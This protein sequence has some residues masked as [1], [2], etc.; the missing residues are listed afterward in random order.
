MMRVYDIEICQE[1]A[2]SRGGKCLTTEYKNTNTRMWWECA[3]GHQWET[4]WGSIL[5]NNSWCGICANVRKHSIDL[6]RELAVKNGGRCLSDDY[7]NNTELLLWEC[8]LQHQWNASYQGVQQGKWCPICAK[9]KKFS[10]VDV[11]NIS[12][13]RGGK[14]LA[15]EY[16]NQILRCYGSVSMDING[17]Q[18]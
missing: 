3:Y 8:N 10:L 13:S 18:N 14:C 6:A 11:Q 5:Y 12:S 17:K 4:T 1:T 16:I 9:N 2:K 15:T 7:Q